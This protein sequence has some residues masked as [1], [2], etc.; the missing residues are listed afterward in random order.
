MNITLNIG[1]EVSKN[2]LPDGVEEMHLQYEYV[3]EYLK[4]VFGTPMYIALAQS[5]T[6]KTVVV[7]YSSVEYVLPKLFWL[8]H[9]FKQDCIAYAIKDG[10]NVLGGALIGN[11]AHEWNF[12]IFDE[13]YFISAGY[14]SWITVSGYHLTTRIECSTMQP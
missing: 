11:Y 12:G 1:L 5:T 2:Y 4:Q 13:E 14:L 9:E 10:A 7:Q 8:A 3:K 6:E